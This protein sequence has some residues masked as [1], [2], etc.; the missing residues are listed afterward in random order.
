MNLRRGMKQAGC[1]GIPL[2]VLGKP[3]SRNFLNGST[4]TETF[5]TS[6]LSARWPVTRDVGVNSSREDTEIMP[7]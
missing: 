3:T 6:P 4:A 2:T 5:L 1:D 7:L